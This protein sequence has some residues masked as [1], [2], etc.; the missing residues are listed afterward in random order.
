MWITRASTALRQAY[1]AMSPL[2]V[3][4]D[5][6]GGRF[7]LTPLPISYRSRRNSDCSSQLQSNDTPPC[8][9]YE[10][11]VGKRAA[12]CDV[13]NSFDGGGDFL[14]QPGNATGPLT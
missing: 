12:S 14:L 5:K 13:A 1:G 6:S 8:S 7:E 2:N 10:V 9:V 3:V 4:S 11:P